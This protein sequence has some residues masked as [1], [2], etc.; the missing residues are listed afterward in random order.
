MLLGAAVAYTAA[1]GGVIMLRPRS[2]LAQTVGDLAITSACLLAL[3]GCLVAWRR[4]G[5]TARGWLGVT[6]AVAVWSAAQL[7]WTFYGFTRD[8]V[9]PFPSPADAGYLGY[10][11]PLVAGL[12]LF[13]RSSDRQVV[14]VRVLL[15]GLLISACLL[16][17][18]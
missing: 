14:R 10:S 15:D 18:S 6:C 17:V 11:L 4:G 2:P 8:H 7:L 12:L 1:V 16:F 13:P 5:P 3:A 9:Y